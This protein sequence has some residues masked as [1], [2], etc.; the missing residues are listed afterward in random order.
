MTQYEI[1]VFLLCLI[2]FVL[3]TTLSSVCLYLITKLSVRLI[4]V[5][6]EDENILAEQQK[7]VSRKSKYGKIVD[8]VITVV[9]CTVLLVAFTVSVLIAVSDDM[10][11]DDVPTYR[12][13]KTGSMAEKHPDN[14]YLVD[15]RLDDQIQTFDLIRTE[16]LPAEQDLQLYDIV[17][18]QMDDILVV[19]RIIEI[20]EPNAAHP[21]ERYFRLQGD[22][23]EA[24][25]RFPVRYAQMLAIYRGERIPFVGSFVLFMQSPAG[26]LCVLLVVVA[27]VATP[28]LNRK[29]LQER[30]QR[31]ALIAPQDV[32]GGA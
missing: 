5:G 10:P 4:R 2:V 22:A 27:I 31:Y 26:W 24:P 18:Y 25:D 11:L 9:L 19:H 13:V 29:L 6:A 15:N 17:V 23:S 28:I 20:E 32:G 8:T 7:V 12:V 14:R 3:L 1:Y 16:K 30:Q 21:N